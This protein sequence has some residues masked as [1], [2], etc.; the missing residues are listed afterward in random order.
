MVFVV[1]Y[2]SIGNIAECPLDGLLI[3]DQSLTILRFGVAQIV[4]QVTALKNRLHDACRVASHSERSRNTC[5]KKRAMTPRSTSGAEKRYLR[6]EHGL[7]DADIG[8]GG[9]QVLLG[10]A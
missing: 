8:V 2:Q 6:K 10:L 5:S 4:A 1:P 9:N 7:G 3:A